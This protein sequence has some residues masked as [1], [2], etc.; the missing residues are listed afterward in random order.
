MDTSKQTLFRVGVAARKLGL[1]PITVRRWLKSG[2]I[3]AVHIGR[4]ARIPLTE[5]ERLM[6]E[7]PSG[8]VALYGRV[9][10]HDQ[11][12][13]LD[14][15]LEVL[16]LWAQKERPTSETLPLSDIGSGLNAER[17]GLQKLIRLAQD[18]QV[19]EVVVT[20]KDRLTRFGFEYLHALFLT[21]G[22][23]LTVLNAAEGTTPE[24]ELTDDLIAI[25]TSFS[26]RLYG[27]RS[28]KQQELVKCAKQALKS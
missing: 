15:Q 8:T 26:G 24:K 27:L 22:V 12:S 2:K 25:I 17:K 7:Q 28:H 13:T 5:I 6:G 20:Y 4:E 19:V 18:R 9:S 21:C 16:Q 23:R 3:K 11:K 14:T 1:H 10:S